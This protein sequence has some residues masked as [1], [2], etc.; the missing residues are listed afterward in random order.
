MKPERF[1]TLKRKE[2]LLIL[3]II[4]TA[5]RALMAEEGMWIPMLIEKYRLEDMKEAGL[6]LEAEDIYSINR[7]CLKDAVVI[8]G[9]GCTG[10]MISSEGLLLTNHHC[11]EGNIQSLSSLEHDYLTGGY[12]AGTREE[13]LPCEG[14]SVTFL[15]YME[16]VTGRVEQG[17]EQGMDRDERDRKIELNQGEIIRKA[18]RGTYY[19]ASVV[20]FYYGNAYYLFMYETFRDVRLVGAPPQSI[21]N[22]GGD[23]DNWI[24]PRHTGDFSLFRVYADAENQPADYS[25]ENI[26][27]KPRRSLVIN[28]RGVSEGD[29]TMVMGYPAS[30]TRYLHSAAVRDMI[31]SSLPVKTGLRTTRLEIMERYMKESDLVRLQYTH[32]YRMISNSW[33]KWQ[34]MLV[35]LKRNHTVEKKVEQEKAFQAW[36]SGDGIRQMKYENVLS[37]LSGHHQDMR[38]YC[39][40]VDMMNE[41]VLA[42]ELIRQGQQ[43]LGMMQTGVPTKGLENQ[44]ERFF[45]VF[46]VPVDR[47]IFAAMMQAYHENMPEK[48]QPD[49]LSE[50]GK[51]YRGDYHRFANAVYAGT[52]LGDRD[53]LAGLLKLYDKDPA[54]ALRKLNHDPIIRYFQQ[55][56]ELY[57]QG[58]Y[59]AYDRMVL[60][61]TELYR[62]YMAG[63]LEMNGDSMLFP[64]ANRTMR[65]SYGKV[66]SYRPRDAVEYLQA[67]TLEGLMEKN[68]E[69]IA[70]YEVPERLVQLYRGRDFGRYAGDGSMPVCFIATNHTSGGNSGSPVLDAEGSLIG[71]NFDRVW[72]GT[73]SDID[74][75]AS[76]CRNIAVDIR[77]ILFII[78]KFAGAGYLLQEM[79]IL[80]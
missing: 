53:R 17:L 10:E 41:A 13:E 36:V 72:E 57:E 46:H 74:Y 52:A 77:Y 43:L 73:M 45:R 32:K 21:G 79:D 12:W 7:D 8:F 23:L 19:A 11:G 2:A 80:W 14:L 26:P 65:I 69:G 16:D 76:V 50:A 55:F 22:F 40:A 27:Y 60:D 33:K 29:F 24:W 37:D 9:R 18:T 62:R 56:S 25:P 63:L 4:I 64:D 51:R 54:S 66:K 67:T 68:R 20:P 58:I 48:Y 31:E 39:F 1:N 71:L 78:D 5:C 3:A 49:F 15:R 6:R 47:D 70:D 28:A 75:D 44:A 42:V 34:G 59:P 35:G 38:P 61:G 30:T